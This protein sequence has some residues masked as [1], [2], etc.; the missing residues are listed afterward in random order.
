MAKKPK[1]I[2]KKVKIKEPVPDHVK[3]KWLGAF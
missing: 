3:N 1:K 2:V